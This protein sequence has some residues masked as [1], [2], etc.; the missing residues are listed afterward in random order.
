MLRNK[1]LS[2]ITFLFVTIA[3]WAQEATFSGTQPVIY[4]NTEN[5]TPITSKEDY[6]Q[7]TYYLDPMGVEGI[8][9]LGSVDNQL[10][11]E[12][13]GRGNYTWLGFD[14]KPYRLKFGA[15]TAIMG[16]NKSK[17]FALMANA[18]DELSGLRNAVGY[19]LA[20]MIGMPWTPAAKPVE[21]VLNGEY[22]GLYFLTETIRID[23]DR[24]N[25]VEQADEETD[26]YAI[27]GGWLVEIDNYDSDPHVR[28]TEGNGERIIFTYKTPEVLSPQQE[29][30]LRSQMETIDGA[31]YAENK[32]DNSWEEYIDLDQ[33][34]RFYIVQEILDNAES[35]HGSCYMYREIGENEK[36]KF[37]PVW[38]FGN[39]FRRGEG[40][41]IHQNPPYGQTWIAEIA[42]FP[43]F[44]ERVQEIW[45]E[46]RG[47]N[48]DD[49]YTYIDNYVLAYEK[50]I[51]ADDKRWP[52]YGSQNVTGDGTTM[53]NNI[54]NRVK[55][56]ADNWGD[57]EKEVEETETSYTVYFTAQG[58]EWKNIHAY[59]WDYDG[60]VTLFLGDWPGTIMNTTTIDGTE[61]YTI[62]FDPLFTT[63][64]P[65]IIFNDGK[66][67]VGEHQ[68]EDLKLVNQG[69]YDHNG[70]INIHTATPAVK[71]NAGKITITHRTISAGGEIALYN[72]QGILVA[73]GNNNVTAPMAGIYI[74]I[75]NG[76][77]TK[78]ALR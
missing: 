10:P 54:R 37:G 25:I 24:V 64:N 61:Y 20:R 22:I 30:F 12:I 72:T 35:F 68:T 16:M 1:I 40:Q 55:F 31:I 48:F 65:M 5:N 2:L 28:I 14:K 26:S 63:V 78:V 67:G 51:Q 3:T 21:V 62:T 56:L 36:W 58:T 74:V 18:D 13:R 19:E 45:K 43:H 59:S 4:I 66:S 49:I 44:Q 50:A 27:T 73:K 70:L 33:L 15:K 34:V 76:T 60:S 11:L 46:F 39:T 69:I 6:L 29:D 75:Y 38:D 47:N 32:S 23:S 41:F 8:E 9:A 53:K 7:A 71:E 52:D 77:A 57:A 17:H 42:K